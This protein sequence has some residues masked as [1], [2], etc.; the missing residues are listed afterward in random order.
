[1][2]PHLS[3]LTPNPK[4]H[5]QRSQRSAHDQRAASAGQLCAHTTVRRAVSAQAGE[6]QESAARIQTAR[7]HLVRAHQQ[8]R[9]PLYS[10]TT[11]RPP[12]HKLV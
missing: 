1:M 11:P 6:D 8:L 2:Y 10:Y 5:I 4:I 9:A 12:A 7:A 3:A